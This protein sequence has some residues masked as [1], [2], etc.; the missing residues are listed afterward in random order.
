MDEDAFWALIGRLDWNRQ[1]DDEAV[2]EPVV[3]DLARRTP[4]EVE[5]FDE[6]LARQLFALDTRAHAR[7]CGAPVWLGEP[8]DVDADEFLY[9]RCAVVANGREAYRLVLADPALMPTDLEFEAVLYIGS[10]ALGRIL[11]S[12]YPDIDT[13][14]SWETFSNRD[15]WT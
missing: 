12:E 8:D 7:A 14:T 2:V 9:A 15:G 10:Q 4:A 11:G 1:G 6:L 3:A 5:A 13:A